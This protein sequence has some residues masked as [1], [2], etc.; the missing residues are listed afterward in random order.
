M[1][2]RPGDERRA[3]PVRGLVAGAALSTRRAGDPRRPGADHAHRRDGGGR[4]HRARPSSSSARP[5]GAR[6]PAPGRSRTELAFATDADPG[7]FGPDSMTWR[8][9]RRPVDAHRRVAR[10]VPAGAASARDGGRRRP[11]VVPGGPARP[12]GPHRPLRRRHHLRHRAPRPSGRSARCAPST[13]ACAASRPTAVRTTRTIRRCSRGCTTSRSTRSSPRTAATARRPLRPGRRRSLRRGDGD[14]G[15]A[16]RRARTCP[17]PR[18]E[19]T[20]WIEA[21][22]DLAMTAEAR[23]AIRFLVLPNLPLPMLPTYAVIAAAAADLLPFHR[24]RALGLWPVPLADPLVVRPAATSLLAL[25]GWAL[26]P[27]PLPATRALSPPPRSAAQRAGAT[28]TC[29]LRCWEPNDGPVPRSVVASPGPSSAWSIGIRSSDVRLG[30]RDLEAVAVER[31]RRAGRRAASWRNDGDQGVALKSPSTIRRAACA[32][33]QRAAALS[34]PVPVVGPA[35]RGRR[36]GPEHDRGDRPVG[37]PDRH[38]HRRRAERLVL[39]MAHVGDRDP[40][41]HDRPHVV[42]GPVL[43]EPGGRLRVVAR[44]IAARRTAGRRTAAGPAPRTR[45]AASRAR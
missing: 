25:L 43:R 34:E 22:P 6:W 37:G 33:L 21:V 39:R 19:L 23:A 5:P 11:L 40:A 15:P 3:R 27:P 42:R 10:A 41:E 1:A 38:L 4:G 32:R 36:V 13:T 28:V 20:A 30:P 35:R 16:A 24:R 31:A 44:A 45:R 17:R 7:W 14:R 2:T 26:G 18:P 12:P 29:R 8:D 9:P